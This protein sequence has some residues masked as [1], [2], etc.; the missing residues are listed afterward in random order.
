MKI[1]DWQANK[2][3][4]DTVSGTQLTNTWVLKNTVKWLW[5]TFLANGQRIA[6]TFTPPTTT[7]SIVFSFIQKPTPSLQRIVTAGNT[8]IYVINGSLSWD[9]T[10]WAS[11]KS[12]VVWN[13]WKPHQWVFTRDWNITNMYVDWLLVLTHTFVGTTTTSTMY[14]GWDSTLTRPFWGMIFWVKVYDTVFT[15]SEINKEYKQFLSLQPIQ[16]PKTNFPRGKNTIRENL[17]WSISFKPAKG[18]LYETITGTPSVSFLWSPTKDG[19]NFAYNKGFCSFGN[20]LNISTFTICTTFT[21]IENQ[22]WPIVWKGFL[23]AYN[24]GWGL[25]VTGTT[26]GVKKVVF[27]IR[28]SWVATEYTI[29]NLTPYIRKTL[30][31]SRDWATGQIRYSINWGAITTVSWVVWTISSSEAFTVWSSTGSNFKGNNEIENLDIYS[32]IFT[33]SQH[34]KYHN[35]MGYIVFK[36]DFSFEKADWQNVVPRGWIAGTWKYKIATELTGN[37]II[38]KGTNYLQNTIAGTIAYPLKWA[39][40]TIEFTLYRS[41]LS[42]SDI[43]VNIVS[44]K[45]ND[46]LNINWY[47]AYIQYSTNR[48]VIKE[49]PSNRDIMYT[50]INYVLDNTYC[51]FKITRSQSG[52]FTVYI[53]GWAFGNNYVLASVIWGTGNNPSNPFNTHQKS[54]FLVVSAGLW[55]R[56]TDII[57]KSTI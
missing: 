52:V 34:S 2:W 24:N 32:S 40:W 26:W 28:I 17:I 48:F 15:Q 10:N 19:V 18:K 33:D 54:S 39:Y 3:I 55:S 25:Y 4:I 51:R 23:G 14:I 13:Y 16:P 44:D 27:Q 49:S 20:I 29:D 57:A 9:L 8:I 42:T 43:R 38:K 30:V 46:I 22:Q 6:T 47:G 56:I 7:S 50:P 12:F 41:S 53:K 31:I 45:I 5:A 21:D 11:I 37:S 36:E 1:F 35:N